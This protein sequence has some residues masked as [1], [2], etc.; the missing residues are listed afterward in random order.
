MHHFKL[1]AM[2][3]VFTP[4]LAYMLLVKELTP[5]TPHTSPTQQNVHACNKLRPD[6]RARRGEE[7]DPHH[8][9]SDHAAVAR[10][11]APCGRL[12]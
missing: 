5:A 3:L 7:F 9:H 12:A 2:L 8:L 11:H 1:A 6:L 10:A 4:S